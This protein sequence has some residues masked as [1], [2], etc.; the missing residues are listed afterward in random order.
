MPSQEKALS[1]AA[2][3]EGHVRRLL[4][5]LGREPA[6]VSSA[7]VKHFCKNARNLRVLR[8]RLLAEEYG[9]VGNKK[10]ELQVNIEPV[11]PAGIDAKREV[12]SAAHDAFAALPPSVIARLSFPPA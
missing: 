12:V 4:K 8:Y 9:A 7:T 10:G 2:A 3:V 1:D 5:K 11:S 6:S